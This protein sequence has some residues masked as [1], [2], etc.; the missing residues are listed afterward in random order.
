[1]Q[2]ISSSNSN[3]QLAVRADDPRCMAIAERYGD[4]MRFNTRW[5]P[6][7]L[8][9]IAANVDRSVEDGVPS[10]V[11]LM[12]TYGKEAIA[13]NLNMHLL[14]A[15]DAMGI[16]REDFTVQDI[17]TTAKLITESERLRTLNYAFLLTFFAKL[18]QGEYKV[19]SGAPYKI[20]EALNEYADVALER[21][22]RLK[23]E[24][25]ER[26]EQMEDSN[27]PRLS[28]DEYAASRGIT[29]RNPLEILTE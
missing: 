18:M 11:M 13:D 19:Y 8:W 1:M 16:N 10:L 2:L 17:R 4:L 29:Q 5:C 3:R 9:Y 21:Q 20:M 23:K 12:L 24:A 27:T 26:R 28:W 7:N 25:D 22:R 15:I 6:A 14:S